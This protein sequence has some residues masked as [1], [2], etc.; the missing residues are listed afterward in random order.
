[1]N[2]ANVLLAIGM[3]SRL[4]ELSERAMRAGKDISEEEMND[5]FDR[6]RQANVSWQQAMKKKDGDGGGVNK[7]KKEEI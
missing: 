6:A 1:M 4:M 5:A 2:M 7:E 3:A